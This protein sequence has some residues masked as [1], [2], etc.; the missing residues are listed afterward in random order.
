MKT[1]AIKNI[2]FGVL[3]SLIPFNMKLF[4][5]FTLIVLILFSDGYQQSYLIKKWPT[6]AIYFLCTFLLIIDIYRLLNNYELNLE[7]IFIPIIMLVTLHIKLSEQFFVG[8]AR[9]TSALFFV[10]FLFNLYTVITGNDLFG[11]VVDFR[12]NDIL[13]RFGGIYGHAYLN[14]AVN[15]MGFICAYYFKNR[16]LLILAF[17]SLLFSGSLRE[18][19][20][21]CIIVLCFFCLKFNLSKFLK[22]FVLL[23]AVSSIFFITILVS[24]YNYLEENSNTLRVHA[25]VNALDVIEDKTLF[26]K[27]HSNSYDKDSYKMDIPL[28][29]TLINNGVAES[30][31]L[32]YGLHFGILFPFIIFFY[33]Y[34]LIRSPSQLTSHI[35]RVREMAVLIVFSDTFYGSLLSTSSFSIFACLIFASV[36]S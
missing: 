25:W 16:F 21:A 23:A 19:I 20:S 35:E 2:L 33:L 28:R 15:I 10:N 5:P 7:L 22:M 24:N 26:G 6:Y 8:L 30:Q 9:Y 4:I 29:E 11:R 34:N 27:S 32:Q 36:R 13:M 31:Y 3:L 1:F 14:N 17:L 18:P 12:E